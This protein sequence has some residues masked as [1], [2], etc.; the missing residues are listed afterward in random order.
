MV[1]RL[2]RHPYAERQIRTGGT[3]VRAAATV[4][5]QNKFQKTRAFEA[6]SDMHTSEFI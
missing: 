6:A 3:R 4:E 2:G 1:S 5:F